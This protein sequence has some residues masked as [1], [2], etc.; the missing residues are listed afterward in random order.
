M[1]ATRFS[2]EI[3]KHNNYFFVSETSTQDAVY[4]SMIQ[5]IIEYEIIL[6]L[7]AYVSMLITGRRG[8]ELQILEIDKYISVPGIQRGDKKHIS[9]DRQL[10]EHKII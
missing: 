8:G 7:M 1:T 4:T 3:V 9:S 5:C 10:F 2:M 6:I